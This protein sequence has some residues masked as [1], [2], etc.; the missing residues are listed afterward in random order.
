[1][2]KC[3]STY[4]TTVIINY[5]HLCNPCI[6]K[7]SKSAD[8]VIMVLYILGPMGTNVSVSFSDNDNS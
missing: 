8:E 2:Y 1:M 3:M 7:Y 5:S 6:G 4:K